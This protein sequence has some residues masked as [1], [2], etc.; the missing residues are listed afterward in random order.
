MYQASHGP[1]PSWTQMWKPD[2]ATLPGFTAQLTVKAVLVW[3]PLSELIEP[4]GAG[5]HW[6]LASISFQRS[7]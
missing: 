3:L 2:A 7:V 5:G 1:D 6:S 4:L